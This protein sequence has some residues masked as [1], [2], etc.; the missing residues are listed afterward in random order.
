MCTSLTEVNLSACTSLTSIGYGA[1]SSCDALKSV[2]FPEG[3]TG[4]Y[5]TE[6]EVATSGTNVVVT[7][8]STNASNLTGQYST[9]YWKRNA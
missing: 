5:V 2:V 8:A 3:S 9:Y 6:D 1:F 4:W 7:N